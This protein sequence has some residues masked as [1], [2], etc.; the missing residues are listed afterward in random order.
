MVKVQSW[1]RGLAVHKRVC[2][3]ALW[4]AGVAGIAVRH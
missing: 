2:F 4:L 1:R 3:V